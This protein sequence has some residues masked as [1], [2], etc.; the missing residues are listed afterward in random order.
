MHPRAQPFF[1]LEPVGGMLGRRPSAAVLQASLALLLSFSSWVLAPSCSFLRTHPAWGPLHGSAPCCRN[2]EHVWPW[3]PPG[4]ELFPVGAPG[5]SISP[6]G[7]LGDPAPV[8][9][10]QVPGLRG[11]ILASCSDW[12]LWESLVLLGLSCGTGSP[13]CLHKAASPVSLSMFSLCVRVA[14]TRVLVHP[15]TSTQPCLQRPIWELSQAD[16]HMSFFRDAVELVILV[17]KVK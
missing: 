3:L 6:R 12:G 9:L 4:A 10:A 17:K 16:F 8:T 14:A 7:K 5:C 15:G 2:G 13:L 1:S 11:S